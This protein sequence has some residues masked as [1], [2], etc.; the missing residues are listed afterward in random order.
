MQFVNSWRRPI[1]LAQGAD[2]CALDLPDGRYRLTLTDSDKQ[3]TRWEIV[4]AEVAA[5]QA[6]LSRG[7]EGTADQEWPAGSVIYQAP[8]AGILQ[9]LFAELA[10]LQARVTALEGAE[11]PGNAL[12]DA[13]G[14]LLADASG[15]VL[16]I[17]EMV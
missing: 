2:S 8:T 5:G 4:D 16:T 15:E 10:A 7:L 13:E 11:V 6:G 14:N 17:G 9:T 1:T 3:A 12:T